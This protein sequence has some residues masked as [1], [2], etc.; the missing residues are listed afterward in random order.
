MITPMEVM[1]ELS[2]K[3]IKL[4]ELK[5]RQDELDKGSR[6]NR[7]A[8]TDLQSSFLKFWREAMNAQRGTKDH[9]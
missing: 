9:G 3:S 8:I 1:K 6:A 4:Q 7:K 2:E 5:E